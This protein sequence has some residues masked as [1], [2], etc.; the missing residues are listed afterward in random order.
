MLQK[1]IL[2]A[3]REIKGGQGQLEALVILFFRK[4]YRNRSR[5]DDSIGPK[6]AEIGVILAILRPF[7][8]I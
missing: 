5:Q 3:S 4:F 1:K 7:E 6:I 8:N 2:R